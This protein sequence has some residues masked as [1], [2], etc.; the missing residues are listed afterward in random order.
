MYKGS[1]TTGFSRV[2]VQFHTR[3]RLLD[4][5]KIPPTSVAWSLNFSLSRYILRAIFRILISCRLPSEKLRLHAAEAGGIPSLTFTGLS[6]CH[7]KRLR[8]SRQAEE[9]SLTPV[10]Q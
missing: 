3:T 10:L 5:G 6:C 8:W 9:H 4:F 2:E 1:D 7:E